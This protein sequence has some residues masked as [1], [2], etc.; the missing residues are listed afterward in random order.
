MAGSFVW[1]DASQQGRSGT[2]VAVDADDIG[3]TVTGP[4]GPEAGVWVIAE[5]KGLP[6]KFVKIVVT[7]D[8]GRYAIPDLPRGSF[9]VFVRGYGLIDSP[10]VTAS[11][12]RQLNLKAVVAPDG[13]AAA[14]Y[15]PPS[16]WFSMMEIAKG[17]LSEQETVSIIKDCL[18]CHPI[19][20]KGTRT[21]PKG[22]H[23]T[24]LAAWDERTKKGGDFSS[25]MSGT[26]QRLGPQRQMFA[27]W[28]DRIAAGAYPQEAPPR[29]AGLERN[30]VISL[31]N[32]AWPAAT[33]SDAQA[34]YDWQATINANGLVYGA[35]QNG[36]V[37]VYLDPL[38]HRVGQIETGVE[39]LR[40]IAMDRQ[41]RVWVTGNSPQGA[42]APDFCRPGSGNKFV[43]Y[44]PIGGR[45]KTLVMYDPKTQQVT[46][47]PTCMP[48]DHNFFGRE[49]D[50]PLYF[51][52]NS[53][54]G[55]VSTA[56]WDKT[57]DPAA[58]QGWCPGVADTNGDGRIT[59]WT[60]F[61][62]PFDPKLDRRL[63]FGCYSVAVSPLDGSLWCSG[64]S[65]S[66]AARR[67]GNDC[68][69]LCRPR[70]TTSP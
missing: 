47:I 45:G 56:T 53:Q 43:E 63:R 7:D 40:S 18:Q 25:M 29:P 16:Y 26:F 3:G 34:T 57:K 52:L 1:L 15:Y 64:I 5:A 38:E 60:E 48:I 27:D 67:V 21:L 59:Q 14:E 49:A 2:A 32:W 42:A 4:N 23:P 35:H 20:D 68:D 61:D 11:P 37:L 69:R 44:S 6:T 70:Y 51:G 22:A 39:Y 12:G 54:I 62:A 65:A 33:R 36:S 19:G 66:A 10:R 13:R 28:T 17:K 30:V 41:G 24:S 8:Q 58:S 50:V 9:E 46:R 31:W 55:W